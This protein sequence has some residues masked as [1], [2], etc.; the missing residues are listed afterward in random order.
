MIGA[1][2]AHFHNYILNGAPDPLGNSLPSLA[3]LT[4]LI[5]LSLVY[6]NIKGVFIYSK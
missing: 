3:M 6:N 1:T 4:F 2:V 5:S